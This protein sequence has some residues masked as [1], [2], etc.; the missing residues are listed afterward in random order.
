MKSV[1][2]ML[3]FTNVGLLNFGLKFFTIILSFRALPQKTRFVI[4]ND[5]LKSLSKK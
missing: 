5:P 1:I 2:K 4:R 3:E